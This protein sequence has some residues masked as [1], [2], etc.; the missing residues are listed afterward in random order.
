MRSSKFAGC[1]EVALWVRWRLGAGG[2]RTRQD[3][4]GWCHPHANALSAHRFS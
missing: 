2:R 3:K 4:R 1:S